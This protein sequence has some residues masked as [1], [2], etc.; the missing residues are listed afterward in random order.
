MREKPAC[1]A[2]LSPGVSQ[3]SPWRSIELLLLPA[4]PN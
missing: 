2:A 4:V 1:I 3:H